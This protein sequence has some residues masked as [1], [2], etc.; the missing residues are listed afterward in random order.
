MTNF[1]NIKKL[2]KEENW[3]ELENVFSLLTSFEEDRDGNPEYLYFFQN[4]VV[5]AIVLSEKHSLI[6][7]HEILFSLK[8]SSGKFRESLIY[9]L[10]KSKTI[11]PENFFTSLS[12]EKEN[13]EHLN[14]ISSDII[15]SILKYYEDN[16]I[17]NIYDHQFLKTIFSKKAIDNI[18]NMNQSL[19]VFILKCSNIN[20]FFLFDT[21]TKKENFQFLNIIT[22]HWKNNIQ[23][24]D[25]NL[26][27]ENTNESILYLKKKLQ[28]PFFPQPLKQVVNII[29][30]DLEKINLFLD[31]N[32]KTFESNKKNKHKI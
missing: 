17:K 18:L 30:E 19:F 10:V 24:L 8:F 11:K 3:T 4:N 29:L 2:I 23:L 28:H 12:S 25:S 22:S 9:S 32:N 26:F 31:L 5:E 15:N 21:Y 13:F 6:E 7:Q 16:E 20:D 27:K 1:E 14:F